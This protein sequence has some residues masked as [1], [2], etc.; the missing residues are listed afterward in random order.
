MKRAL[1][2]VLI[3]VGFIFIFN[4]CNKTCTCR[5]WINGV[6]GE[7]YKIELSDNDPNSCKEKSTIA[8]VNNKKTGI[9][10]K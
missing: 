2:I 4:S 7:P 8:I 3:S 1:S 6:A 5:G 10:C 9:E